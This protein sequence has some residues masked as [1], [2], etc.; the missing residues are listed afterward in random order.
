MG[1]RTSA[2][3]AWSLCALSLASIAT[4]VPSPE[5]V[6]PNGS[7]PRTSRPRRRVCPAVHVVRNGRRSNRLSAAWK[8]D[9]LDLLHPEYPRPIR[10]CKRGVRSVHPGDQA[11]LA[12]RGRGDSLA[13]GVVRRAYHL[14][15][16]S[17]Y[18]VPLPRRATA[19]TPLAT[20]RLGQ[21]RR[22][23]AALRLEL[24]TWAD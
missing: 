2:W 9:R 10:V 1:R 19:L 3:L 17:F 14:R 11:R 23:L 16:V 7:P 4:G 6:Y 12:S 8:S 21:P 13:C 20:R 15:G 24:R 5:C 22:H 18:L